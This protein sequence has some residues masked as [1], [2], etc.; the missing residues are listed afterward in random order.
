[1]RG[2]AGQYGGVNA[3]CSMFARYMLS[4]YWKCARLGEDRYGAFMVFGAPDFCRKNTADPLHLVVRWHRH[5]ALMGAA[6]IWEGF[7][8]RVTQHFLLT[9]LAPATEPGPADQGNNGRGD[10]I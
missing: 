1:M 3:P 5:R 6:V 8:F 10:A 7:E 2:N 9:V 4:A